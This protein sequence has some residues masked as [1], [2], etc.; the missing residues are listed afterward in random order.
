LEDND[1]N[2]EKVKIITSN[3]EKLKALGELLSNRSSRDII[4]LLIGKEMYANEIANRLDL[5]PNL[6]VH[7]LK[8]LEELGLLEIKNKTIVKKGKEHRYFRMVPNL[9]IAPNES[10]EEI[11][12]KGIL[13]KF[14]KDGI[15]FFIIFLAASLVY[16]HDKSEGLDIKQ[17]SYFYPSIIVIIGLII[18][19]ILLKK[20]GVRNPK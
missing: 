20:E 1:E 16:F 13:K 19:I 6:V 12:K 15:R 5:R 9:F 7:H 17:D 8:K 14:F 2:Y 4:K 18:E 3:E 11:E 10:K